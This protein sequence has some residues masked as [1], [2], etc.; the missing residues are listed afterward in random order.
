V[1]A[2]CGIEWNMGDKGEESVGQ[3]LG[4][5]SLNPLNPF[6]YLP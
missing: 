1:D 5:M 2:G 6:Y 3:A 4:A